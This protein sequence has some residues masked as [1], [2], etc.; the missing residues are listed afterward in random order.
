MAF[1]YRKA[2]ES[3][4]DRYIDLANMV[5]SM[6]HRPHDFKVLLPK[7]YGDDK[8][9]AHMQYI[10]LNAQDE[11]RALT[12]VMPGEMVVMGE[13][14]KTGYVGTVS[15]HP[16]AR[17]E[18]HMKQLM[19]IALEDMRSGG[20]DISMLGG[21]RQRYEYF[22]YTRGGASLTY[23][24][25]ATNARHALRDADVSGIEIRPISAEDGD[26]IAQAHALFLTKPV[27]GLRAV[28]AFHEIATS[29]TARLLGIHRHGEFIGY[30][31]IGW[32]NSASPITEFML[33][34]MSLTG[35]VIKKHLQDTGVDHCE[36]T[37]AAFNLPLRRAL[38]RFAEDSTAGEAQQL[39]VFNFPKV[40]GAFFKLKASVSRLED[41][42]RSFVI[43]G[44][45]LTVEVA[46]GVPS[47][48]ADAR[49]DAKHLTALDAQ[50]LFFGRDGE[51]F[52][53][54]LPMGWAPL[55]LYLDGA[56]CF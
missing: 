35:A 14:L 45:P 5:F 20:T 43:D 40:V 37:C 9:T 24:V 31:I 51:L 53:E 33:T 28:D 16:Y 7:V 21:Q 50:F 17:G 48:T 38:A 12:A 4:R 27:H 2:N 42:V 41:G 26:A 23:R 39:C 44:Q 52:D 30:M 18:G 36:I 54:P 46:N 56:D 8:Q 19:Q 49:P 11:L 25:T 47:V 15:S 22:G 10:A 32:G 29:W 6:A 1:T 34:D 55:P 3:D 13:R